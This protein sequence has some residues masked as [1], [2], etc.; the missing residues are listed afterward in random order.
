MDLKRYVRVNSRSLLTF[1]DTNH[2]FNP[3]LV[4]KTNGGYSSDKHCG[5]S[6]CSYQPSMYG[7]SQLYFCFGLLATWNSWDAQRLDML[8]MSAFHC[9]L[10]RAHLFR[11]SPCS[12]TPELSRLLKNCQKPGKADSWA[13]LTSERGNCTW[14]QSQPQ[15]HKRWKLGCSSGPTCQVSQSPHLW[16]GK[17]AH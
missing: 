7:T 11:K 17:K 6:C 8:S 12:K 2:K 4:K 14:P 16:S 5:A 3:Q 9:T 13:R 15:I 1:T 10:I